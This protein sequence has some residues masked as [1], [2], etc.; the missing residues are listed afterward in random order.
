M[1]K[2]YS[3]ASYA[4]YAYHAGKAIYPSLP[5]AASVYKMYS[6]PAGPKNLRR[7]KRT[8]DFVQK[9]GYKKVRGNTLNKKVKDLTRM[10]NADNATHT[11]RVSN[12]NR[13]I[14]GAASTVGYLQMDAFTPARIESAIS[15]L[16]YYDPANPATLVT[17][18]GILGTFQ[19]KF[20][21][22]QMYS[23]VVVRNNY[24]V[25]AKVTIYC[26]RPK[27]DTSITPQIAFTN[28]MA[29]QGNPTTNRTMLH[30]T[31]SDQFREL[32]TIEKSKSFE[33]TPGHER[34]MTVSQSA[35]EYDPALGDVHALTYRRGTH[36][37]VF[38]V[39]IEGVLCHDASVS[40]EQ[41][42][43]PAAVDVSV[44]SKFVIKYDAGTNLNDIS[45]SDGYDSFTN[46][47]EVTILH[48]TNQQW[49]LT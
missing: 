34:S 47:E 9:R 2:D 30:Y 7:R 28:G 4:P 12:T 17:A 41:G 42:K 3:Y 15:N 14:C 5:P 39:R 35:F 25:P 24:R 29:D 49:S 23:K 1:P 32:W 6:K 20:G 46:A 21:I 36:T 37:K 10:V 48:N 45:V 11:H 33:L 16:R 44:E 31:D 13:A 8:P 26:L 43:A 40:T 22:H 27:V 18:S 38:V 19:R